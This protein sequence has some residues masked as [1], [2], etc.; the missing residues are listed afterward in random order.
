MERYGISPGSGRACQT[1]TS[2]ACHLTAFRDLVPADG[3]GESA[4]ETGDLSRDFT[5]DA[6]SV[7]FDQKVGAG[8]GDSERSLADKFP[9]DRLVPMT[10]DH[11]LPGRAE[12]DLAVESH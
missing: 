9:L 7:L 6:E 4:D 1:N 12:E 3:R 5:F 10:L 2:A 8:I 11:A